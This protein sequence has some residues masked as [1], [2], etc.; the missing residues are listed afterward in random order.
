MILQRITILLDKVD[1]PVV[2]VNAVTYG[3]SVGL[4]W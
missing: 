1:E 3:G 4:F 2:D